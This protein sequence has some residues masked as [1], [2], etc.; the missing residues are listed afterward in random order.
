MRTSGLQSFAFPP[1]VE[2][3]CSSFDKAYLI[4]DVMLDNCSCI[5]LP[6]YIHVGRL[7]RISQRAVKIEKDMHV[8]DVWVRG[9]LRV[10]CPYPH[11]A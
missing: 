10:T 9:R 4:Q 8:G 1:S 5:V 6:S 11:R 3:S 2:V 7:L